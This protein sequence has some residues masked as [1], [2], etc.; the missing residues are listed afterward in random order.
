VYSRTV[1][2]RVLTFGVSGKLWKNALVMYDRE[3]RTLWSHLTGEAIEGPLVGH[4]L[5]MITAVPK[6]KWKEW[7]TAYPN[8]RVLSVNG[9]EDL[10]RDAYIEYQISNRTGLFR[11]TH[12][13]DR[14]RPKDLVIGV[15]AGSYQKAYPLQKYYREKRKGANWLIQ[16][17]IG[18]IPAIVYFN[19]DNY[20]TAVYDR[21]LKNGV[22][23]TFLPDLE[24]HMATDTQGREWNLFTGQGPDGQ[25][26]KAIPHMRIYWFAWVDFYPQTLLYGI[27]E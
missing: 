22:Q 1:Q 11:P 24:N 6:V 17:Q 16:D 15:K 13:D 27:S 18:D 4:T 10:R 20:A 25:I 19:T 5:D 26:L 21:R 2:G 9:Q 7:Q 23:I 14:L 3:T 12:E 8:T